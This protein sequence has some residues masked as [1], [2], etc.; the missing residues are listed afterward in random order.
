[1]WERV[2]GLCLPYSWFCPPLSLFSEGTGFLISPPDRAFLLSLPE[3]P[4]SVNAALKRR[5][6]AC[7]LLHFY[8]KLVGS[9]LY[10]KISR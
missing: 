3:S 6:R 9:S 1:M 2:G 4:Q 10:R 5:G 8:S 7:A